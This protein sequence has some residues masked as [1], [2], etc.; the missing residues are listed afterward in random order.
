MRRSFGLATVLAVLGLLIVPTP[1][2]AEAP[3]APPGAPTGITATPGAL[4]ATVSWI[5]SGSAADSYTVTSSPGGITATVDGTATSATV[6]GLGYLMRY[7]FTVTGTNSL[8]TGPASAPSEPLVPGAPGGPYHQGDGGTLANIDVTAGPAVKFNIGRDRVH[9]PGLSAA[10]LNLTASHATVATNVQ[11][12]ENDVVEQTVSVAPGEV[13]SSLVVLPAPAELT[14]AAIQVTT[15]T[16]HVQIDFVGYFTNPTTLRDHSGILTMIAP[17]TL[18]DASVAAGSTTNVPVL[19]QAGI[20]SAHVGEVLLN[21]T[22]TSTEGTGVLAIVPSGSDPSGMTTLGFAAGETTA[23]RA[24]VSVPSSGS[25]SIIDT[26]AAATVHVDALGW[27]SD[28]TDPF[29]IGGLY[30]PLPSARLVD[31]TIAGGPIAPGATLNFPVYGQGGAPAVTATAPPTSVFVDITA[32]APIGAGSIAA[33]GATVL[34]YAAVETASRVA[35][36]HLASDG[37]ITLSVAGSATNIQVDLIA[38]FAGDLIV[39]GSTKVMTPDLESAITNVTPSYDALTFRAGTKISPFIQLNDVIVGSPSPLT[40]QGFLLRVQGI[41]TQP[42]GSVVLAT[43]DAAMAEAFSAFTLDGV[44]LSSVTRFGMRANR[45]PVTAAPEAV[46]VTVNPCPGPPPNSSIDSN[47]PSLQLST[48]VDLA[49]S[50]VAGTLPNLNPD[51][52]LHL[53][54]VPWADVALTDLEIQ[55][56]PH[57]HIEYNFSNNTAKAF[58]AWSVGFKYDVEETISKDLIAKGGPISPIITLPL[59]DQPI[60]FSIGPVPVWITPT[61][62]LVVTLDGSISGGLRLAYHFDKWSQVT[63]SYD[64]SAF[65]SGASDHVYA[66]GFDQPEFEGDAELKLAFHVGPGLTF[67]RLCLQNVPFLGEFC[68]NPFTVG[69][70]FSR[71]LKGT[72]SVT[73]TLPPSCTL[74][75][76]WWTLS[77]GF[78]IGVFMRINLF[79]VVKQYFQRDLGCTE[80][81]L[82]Q[83]PGPFVNITITPSPASVPRNG[84]QHFDA[85]ES[86]V[87]TGVSWSLV[88]SN[89]GSL[90]NASLSSV[91]YKAPARAGTYHLRAKSLIDQTSTR[92][93]VINVTAVAPS[94]PIGVTAQLVAPVGATVSWTAPTDDGGAPITDYKVVASD[95]TTIDAGTSTTAI[96]NGLKPG[97]TYTFSVFATNSANL[98]SVAAVSAPLTIPGATP[99]TV[100]PP[101]VDFGSTSPNAI[102]G[103]RTVTVSA[104]S[105]HA[106]TI[107]TLTL[108]GARPGDYTI[109][110]DL[111]SGQV[112]PAGGSCTFAVV[113]TAG[114]LGPSSANVLINDDDATSPQSVSITA[115]VSPLVVVAA[116]YLNTI[117]GG[118]RDTV[119]VDPNGKVFAWGENTFGQLGNGTNTSSSIPVAVS[120]STGLPP[121]A[122][123]SAGF[124]NTVARTTA[125]DVWAWGSNSSGGLGNPAFPSG[126]NVPVQVQGAGGSGNL[127]GVSDVTVGAVAFAA[128]V[129]AA[130]GSVWTWG[131]NGDGELGN[132]TTTNSPTPVQV[133]GPGGVGFLTGVV[134]VAAGERTIVALK[135]DGTVWAWGSNAGDVLGNND[136]AVTMVTT[137]VQVVGLNGV[138]F[139]S[140]IAA[141]GMHSFHALAVASDGTVFAWGNDPYGQLGNG[142]TPPGGPFSIPSPVVVS[143][144]SGLTNKLSLATGGEHS[145][146]ADPGS[147]KAWGWGWNVYGQVGDATQNQRLTPSQVVASVSFTEVAAGTWHSIG[148]GSDGSVWTWGYNFYGELGNGQSGVTVNPTPRAVGGITA[149]QPQGC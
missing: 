19:G 12:V 64:G 11:V 139:L 51:G 44:I 107:S 53:F 89:G 23:N 95:G 141:I 88:E 77:A 20:P 84:T 99:I 17:A 78:C 86:P 143:T 27:F 126:S 29:A 82:L 117:A 118:T 46:G 96:F 144:I 112:V 56:L 119:V 71:Y 41:S 25:I 42:D 75:N 73:C 7:S 36:V 43:R 14:Q 21:V 13:Q 145:L 4:S 114:P 70:D 2:A 26:Y 35:L 110:S 18:F 62:T 30:N 127:A 98:T 132:G 59:S 50:I 111:C 109:V 128:A 37:S 106:L 54:P 129:K 134:K 5:P 102:I 45:A 47:C 113:F 60:R 16:A 9:A 61:I 123:V 65:H 148:L 136:A 52:S 67:Y 79:Y 48:I 116:C 85:T 121:V 3:P 131:Y 1:S 49:N 147:G 69:V 149:A 138:G 38:Y 6:T 66:N 92:T 133:K 125:G 57:F 137:P 135:A 103:P 140:G 40:P 146:A 8:G 108:T 87:P 97:T 76:P 101:T 15:G 120:T 32:V 100:Q 72:A 39:P 105:A 94:N 130:D 34:D 91:D 115:Q 22:A 10:V 68:V 55:V 24:I 28:G 83:A 142:F 93:V 90:S 58:F 63:E 74:A 33:G 81:V 122:E 104:T 31:T 124:F 80:Q